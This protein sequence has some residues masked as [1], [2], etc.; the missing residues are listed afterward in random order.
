MGLRYLLRAG[1]AD[2][3]GVEVE[4]DISDLLVGL[5]VG[6]GGGLEKGYGLATPAVA[7]LRLRD[8]DRLLRG[9]GTGALADGARVVI[10]AYRALDEWTDLDEGGN[11]GGAGDRRAGMGTFGGGAVARGGGRREAGAL[12]GPAQELLR[13]GECGSGGDAVD[14]V[15]SAGEQWAGRAAAGWGPVGIFAAAFHGW[16]EHIGTGDGEEPNGVGARRCVAFGGVGAVGNAVGGAAAA[17]VAEPAGGGL[18]GGVD[19]RERRNGGSVGGAGG[20]LVGVQE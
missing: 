18:A 1:L 20:H 3:Q 19:R 4:T 2:A 10:E 12:G 9:K 16:G 13:L 14:R 6:G 11:A 17:G 7:T 15:V 8:V 5:E